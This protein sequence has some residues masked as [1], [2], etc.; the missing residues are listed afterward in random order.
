MC[1]ENVDL[2]V[3]LFPTFTFE[4]SKDEELLHKIY[5]YQQK[6]NKTTYY[7]VTAYLV[8]KQHEYTTRMH[9]ISRNKAKLYIAILDS[10]ATT[11]WSTT[12]DEIIKNKFHI[13]FQPN[14]YTPGI[15]QASTVRLFESAPY[16][17]IGHMSASPGDYEGG[18][19]S[20][21][22]GVAQEQQQ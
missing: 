7:D 15:T 9:K 21:Y 13:L 4:L 1:V 11:M 22:F 16:K 2:G 20:V 17:L 12:A 8:K 6:P 19:G 14:N 5:L 10:H 18:P 3:C